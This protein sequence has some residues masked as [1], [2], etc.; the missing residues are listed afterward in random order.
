[1]LAATDGGPEGAGSSMDRPRPDAA[2]AGGVT[3]EPGLLGILASTAL[4][5]LYLVR[6]T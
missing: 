1:M 3:A 2:V 5:G 6:W 4:R